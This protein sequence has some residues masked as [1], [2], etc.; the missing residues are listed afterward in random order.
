MKMGCLPR[1]MWLV[2][3]GSF[4]RELTLLTAADPGQVMR[5]ARGRYREVIA[6]IQPF[7]END[8][9]E[10]NIISAAM[11][12]AVYLSLPERAEVSKLERYYAAAMD[13]AL[14]RLFLKCS[15]YYT[16]RYQRS[17]AR[18]AEK[19]RCSTNPYSWQF[20]FTPGPTLDSFDAVFDHCGIYYLFQRLGIGEVVPALCAYDYTMAARTG[21]IFTREFTIAG[22]GP[23]CDCR[24]Q[25]KQRFAGRE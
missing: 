8:A 16:T 2:F 12:A 19:S 13:N 20:T 22:G 15:N 5:R 4:Q 1:G 23:H 7:G 9:L 18:K 17:L 11:L 25:K 6:S 14:M 21:T 24:Y 10:I 3:R